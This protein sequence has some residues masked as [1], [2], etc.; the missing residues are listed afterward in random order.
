MKD[1]HVVLSLEVLQL[2]APQKSLS[3]IHYHH[4]SPFLPDANLAKP[5][6]I[7]FNFQLKHAFPSL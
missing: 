4:L 3:W 1:I 6:K 7:R 5:V 2:F